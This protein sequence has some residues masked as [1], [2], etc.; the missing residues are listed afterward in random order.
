MILSSVFSLLIFFQTTAKTDTQESGLSTKKVVLTIGSAG[1]I[2]FLAKRN[3]NSVAWVSKKH[4]VE[5]LGKNLVSLREYLESKFGKVQHDLQKLSQQLKHF[6]QESNAQFKGLKGDLADL[7]RSQ[8][9]SHTI[10]TEQLKNLESGQ[11]GHE[12]RTDNLC[13]KIDQ[14]ITQNEESCRQIGRIEAKIDQIMQ[15]VGL[16]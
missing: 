7:K 16:H 3:W 6:S 15:K 12:L 14:L 1:A 8:N 2:C 4:L 10:I 9:N 11:V 5:V 13:K